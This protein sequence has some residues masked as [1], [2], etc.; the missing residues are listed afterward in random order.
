M[1]IISFFH[2]HKFTHQDGSYFSPGQ[3]TDNTWSRYTEFCDELHVMCRVVEDN[4]GLIDV[5]RLNKTSDSKVKFRCIPEWSKYQAL[6]SK[7]IDAKLKEVINYSDFVVCRLPSFLGFKAYYFAKLAGKKV[8]CEAVGCPW[9][10]YF[11]HGSFSAKILAPIMF[12]KMR[13]SLKNSDFSIYVTQGF[14]QE[15]YPTNGEACSASNVVIQKHKFRFKNKERVKKIMF[16]GSL[17][18]AYKG[19]KDLILAFSYIDDKYMELNVLGGG[20]KKKYVELTER[21]GI[22]DR[23]VF[24]PPLPGGDSVFHWLSDGDLYVHPSHTEGLPRSLIEAM[25]VGL[26]CIGTTVGGIPELLHENCLVP[27]KQPKI[28]SQKLL[29]FIDNPKLRLEMSKASLAKSKEYENDVLS[30]RRHNFLKASL[31]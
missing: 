18:T 1:T 24:S 3:L 29:E 9:D 20:D 26:P 12:F 23:V 14:L 5:N 21:L 4:E 8:I 6:F 13:N 2:D 11:N 17:N 10:S 7:E 16:I 27:P 19:L 25:S 30:E 22:S 28:L 31:F 15:R